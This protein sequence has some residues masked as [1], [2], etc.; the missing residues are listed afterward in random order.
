MVR[1]S[2]VNEMDE[3]MTEN[4]KSTVARWA[5]LAVSLVVNGLVVG[6]YFGSVET[7]L[8]HVEDHAA[9]ANVHMPLD[10]KMKIFVGRSEYAT[11]GDEIRRA[12]SRIET[13]L[14]RAIERE[15]EK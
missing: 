8:A 9:D 15:I 10:Q 11:S 1:D 2:N 14:D 5:P 6:F 12:L 13:K 7:R 3:Q 4:I